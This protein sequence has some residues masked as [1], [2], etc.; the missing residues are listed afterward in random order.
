MK[1]LDLRSV[2]LDLHDLLATF[3]SSKKFAE[4]RQTDSLEVLGE[5]QEWEW[6]E[7]TRILISSSICGRIEY[8]RDNGLA[9]ESETD[10]GLLWK[11]WSKPDQSDVLTLRE[12]FNKIIH[13]ERVRADLEVDKE[14][15]LTYYN[16]VVYFYGTHNGTEWR[17]ELR[18]VDY[19]AQYFATFRYT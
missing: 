19:V 17:A 4:L 8:D 12:S 9:L 3:L 16:N 18:I 1:L 13:A 7:V 10:L 5:L 14:K 2:F 11:D 6:D 15:E